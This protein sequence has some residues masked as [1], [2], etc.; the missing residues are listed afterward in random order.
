MITEV[1]EDHH[2]LPFL[3]FDQTGTVL[4]KPEGADYEVRKVKYRWKDIHPKMQDV[5]KMKISTSGFPPSGGMF[6]PIFEFHEK[7][8]LAGSPVYLRG[9]FS[10]PAN[11]PRVNP[12]GGFVDFVT[13]VRSLTPE[14]NFFKLL[15]G[16]G[17]G[18]ISEEEARF[19]FST[20][21]AISLRQRTK[22][23]TIGCAGIITS[24]LTTRL[25][26][27]DCHQQYLL[28]R[29]K[30]WNFLR[31]VFGAILVG[32]GVVMILSDLKQHG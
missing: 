4:V 22:L 3:V 21:A 15:D 31:I 18:E 11:R 20:A 29:L 2:E 17:S 8:I 32:A 10:T 5:L 30:N 19:G 9:N 25:Y 14:S 24:S 23:G 1:Y 7:Y 16:N 28:K 13:K 26:I 6:G 12:A 27:A